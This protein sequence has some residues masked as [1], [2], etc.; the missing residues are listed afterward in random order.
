MAIMICEVKNVKFYRSRQYT[1]YVHDR[2]I[3]GPSSKYSM[4]I[5]Y[6]VS[7]VRPDPSML[8]SESL[9]RLQ[10]A[11]PWTMYGRRTRDL[12]VLN[13][14]LCGRLST[15][16]VT[17]PCRAY[18]PTWKLK[19]DADPGGRNIFA[20]N[21][22]AV[23]EMRVHS[24]SQATA[25]VVVK[26]PDDVPRTDQQLGSRHTRVCKTYHSGLSIKLRTLA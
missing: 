15:I 5:K 22:D 20:S 12:N 25:V 2:V 16:L 17:F 18:C 4:Q 13:V 26:E 21:F 10:V 19:H 9:F 6:I 3:E 8:Q 24:Y 14:I 7:E 23:Y 11:L 1:L